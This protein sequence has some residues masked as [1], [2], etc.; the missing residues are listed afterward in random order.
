LSKQIARPSIEEDIHIVFRPIIPLLISLVCGIILGSEYPGNGIW[1][2]GAVIVWTC[3]CL[4]CICRKQAALFF[5]VMLFVSLGYLSIQPW[6]SPRYPADHI[7]HYTD[8]YR[9]AI[10]GRID[11]QPRQINNRTRFVLQ[12]ASLEDR[13]QTYEVTGKLRVTAVGHLPGIKIGDKILLNGRIRSIANFNNPGGFDYEKYMLFKGIAATVYV[14]ADDLTIIERHSPTIFFRILNKVRNRFDVLV[15]KS[16]RTEAQGVMKAL[17]IGDRSKISD[18]TR[19][20]FNR[21]GVGH[22]LAISGLHVGIVATVSFAIFQWMMVRIKPFL[23]RAW[24]RKGAALLSLV[25]VFAYGAVAGLSPSTQRAVI[26]VSLFLL[27]FL[28]E[29]EQ[30]PFNTLSLAALMILVADPPSLFSISFQLSFTTVLAIIFGFSRMQKRA[31]AQKTQM[32]D[33]WRVHLKNRLIGF[34]LVSFFAICGSLPL[35]AFYFNQI[36]VIGL[37]A[38]F[39][40][41]PLVGFIAVP[42]GLSALFVLPLSPTLASG[43]IKIG[44]EILTYALRIV[45]LFADLPFAAVKIVTPSLLEVGCYY[46]LILALLNLRRLQPDAAGRCPVTDEDCMQ[47]EAH[48]NNFV[49]SGVKY[50]LRKLFAISLIRRFRA[51]SQ[52]RMAQVALVLVFVIL[53][54]DTCYWLYQRCWHKDLRITVIDVGHGSSS[55]LELP[56]GHTILVD[57]GGFSDNSAFDVGARILAPFLWRKKIRTID[58]L[59]LSHPNSDHLN[60]LIYIAEHFN[61]KNVWTNNEA[62]NTAG[63]KKFTEVVADRNIFFSV[64][65]DME[66]HKRI[67]GVDFSLLYPPQDFL[68]RKELEK[69]RNSNNNSLVV[70]ASFDSI[71]F[72]FPGDIM[73]AAEKELVQIAEDKLA[74][75]VLIAPHHGSKSSSSEIFLGAVKP[76]VII[77]SSGR[78][79]RFNFPH[80]TVL[81]RYEKRGSTIYR[82]GVNGAL[83]METDGRY[84]KIKPFISLNYTPRLRAGL[85]S[86]VISERNN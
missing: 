4:L 49:L 1:L 62:R 7:N 20:A 51:L 25:P 74:A 5:P 75:T 6:L 32:K 77:I 50:N 58:T 44:I 67:N 56:G 60:G 57:G 65:A 11:S 37:A 48:I 31:D 61:V 23:W 72:L 82:T 22:L 66:R 8:T 83:Q 29:K 84:L 63:Y 10:I 18:K 52:T 26:M 27:T 34:F 19:Q 81:K 59:I 21:A 53:T 76:K 17:I 38:N 71:S 9:G 35:V 40:V 43:C 54:A 30:D 73:A 16:R 36:S 70:K 68:D 28:F 12:V 2:W 47:I 85:K 15:E 55:L 24:T 41:V 79:S 13:F 14:K 69:W 80:P 46:A 42:L 3:F 45:A 39:L 86:P 33:Y 78:K 64:Y